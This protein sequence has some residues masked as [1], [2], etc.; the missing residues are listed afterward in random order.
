MIEYPTITLAISR[1]KDSSFFLDMRTT[2]PRNRDLGSTPER[3]QNRRQDAGKRER[4][5][6]S[7]RLSQVEVGK[8]DEN[9][10]RD[11][12]LDDLQLIAGKPAV[13]DP[14]RGNLKAVYS[15]RAISQLTMM[16]VP[17]GAERCFRCPYQANVMKVL[18][19]TSRRTVD[20]F[21]LSFISFAE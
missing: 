7:H 13:A 1:Q 5:V 21:C 11:G 16:T 15:P 3:K 17:S 9:G 14:I 4:V 8:G 18:E 10:K 12:F 6:P 20:I 19:I 2:I